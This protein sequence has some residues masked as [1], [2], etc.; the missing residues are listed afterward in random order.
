[1]ALVTIIALTV[2]LTTISSFALAPGLNAIDAAGAKILE[3]IRRVG[4]WVGI[5]L[6]SKD[7]IKHVSRGHMEDIGGLVALYGLGYGILYFLP[8]LFDLI[9]SIF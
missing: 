1:M 9:K 5:I 8:W 6:C 3:L 4:Y 7:V 2:D